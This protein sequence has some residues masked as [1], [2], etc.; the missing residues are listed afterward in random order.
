MLVGGVG[1][2]RPLR[3]EI[4]AVVRLGF[5]GF[6][7]DPGVGEPVRRV[8]GRRRHGRGGEFRGDVEFARDDGGG[9]RL[10][11]IVRGLALSLGADLAGLDLQRLGE[12]HRVARQILV[13]VGLDVGGLGGGHERNAMNAARKARNMVTPRWQSVASWPRNAV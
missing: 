4:P 7:R 2:G 1:G 11:Q 8:L 6:D 9:G 3:H 12:P 13:D 5:V 10:A